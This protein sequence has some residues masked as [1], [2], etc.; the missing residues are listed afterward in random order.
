MCAW[1]VRE[2]GWPRGARVATCEQQDSFRAGI[3]ADVA[4]WGCGWLANFEQKFG[5][6]MQQPLSGYGM[7][8]SVVACCAKL[9]CRGGAH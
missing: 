8:G 7:A 2:H 3:V 1:Y 5:V 4:G 9:Y 6:G